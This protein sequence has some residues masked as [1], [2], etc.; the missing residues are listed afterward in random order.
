MQKV[1][2]VSAAPVKRPAADGWLNKLGPGILGC[3]KIDTATCPHPS[4]ARRTQETP[5]PYTQVIHSV[6]HSRWQPDL[7]GYDVTDV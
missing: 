1:R 5:L 7:H 4:P 6:Y 2:L 3:S